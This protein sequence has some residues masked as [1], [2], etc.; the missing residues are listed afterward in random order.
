[1]RLRQTGLLCAC[2][3]LAGPAV[4]APNDCPAPT[5]ALGRPHIDFVQTQVLGSRVLGPTNSLPGVDAAAMSYDAKGTRAVTVLFRFPA[6]WSMDKAH[7]LNSDQEFLVLSG[8]LE[9]DK[10]VY[11]PGDY[12]YFPAGFA[13]AGLRS[14]KGAVVLN[15]YEGE[16]LAFYTSAPEGMYQPSKL[17]RRIASDE[18][19]WRKL[20]KRDFHGGA[21]LSFK[22]LRRDRNS[23]EETWLLKSPPVAANAPALPGIQRF[24]DAVEEMFVIRGE[25]ATPRGL[26]RSGA[27]AWRAPNTPI[28]PFVSTSGFEALIR[29]KGGAAHGRQLPVTPAVTTANTVAITDVNSPAPPFQPCIPEALQSVAFKAYDLARPY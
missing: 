9:F 14:E 26:M 22:M 8:E 20:S 28:G 5:L 2:L 23:G 18:L 15:F 27:Y 13:H 25:V 24:S 19:R 12:A 16:H 10:V 3:L 7:Y 4:A 1:M 21:G 11:G 17:V 6:G 29:S